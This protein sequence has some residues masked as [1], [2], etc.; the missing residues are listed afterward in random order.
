VQIE[1]AGLGK[2]DQ[3]PFGF[4]FRRGHKIIF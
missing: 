2:D 1:P 4:E 3:I